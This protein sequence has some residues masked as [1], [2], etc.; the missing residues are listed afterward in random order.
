MISE[1]SGNRRFFFYGEI[2]ESCDCHPAKWGVAFEL[3][4]RNKATEI[5]TPAF[6]I[7][8]GGCTHF[9][10]HFSYLYAV[11]LICEF[12]NTDHEDNYSDIFHTLGG[13]PALRPMEHPQPAPH[14][15]ERPL[16]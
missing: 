3:N 15:A 11:I 6:G 16:F 4:R 1:A 2:L 14:G 7:T 13:K 10:V 12:R 8:L 9:Y 5:N